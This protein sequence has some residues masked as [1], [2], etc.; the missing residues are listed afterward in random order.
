M[1]GL[2]KSAL[3][4]GSCVLEKDGEKQKDKTLEQW[5]FWIKDVAWLF[6]A[7]ETQE[8]HLK[9][10]STKS[11][12]PLQQLPH[13]A[14]PHP[15]ETA[16]VSPISVVE[17]E[18]DLPD[19]WQVPAFFLALWAQIWAAELAGGCEQPE[20]L[21]LNQTSQSDSQLTDYNK[22]SLLVRIARFQNLW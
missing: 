15:H 3:Q 10:T 13:K 22:V 1:L 6:Y 18:K 12:M 16:V 4:R 11:M 20:K 9:N 7:I 19:S 14:R 2:R 8:V 5:S 17:P 21:L